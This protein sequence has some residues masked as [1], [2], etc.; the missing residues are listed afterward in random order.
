MHLNSFND[1]KNTRITLK[2]GQGQFEKCCKN[3]RDKKAGKVF[4]KSFEV[5]YIYIYI[6]IYI[7]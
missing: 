4:I 2:F 5:I 1:A 7:Q 3:I 6:Y